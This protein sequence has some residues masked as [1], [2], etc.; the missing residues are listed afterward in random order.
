MVEAMIALLVAWLIGMILLMF[1]GGMA[2]LLR[3][4]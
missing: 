1:A 3:R 4:L 2:A